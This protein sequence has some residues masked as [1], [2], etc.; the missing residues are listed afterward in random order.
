[1]QLAGDSFPL[2]PTGVENCEELIHKTL[3]YIYTE[4]VDAVN[5]VPLESKDN[6]NYDRMVSATDRCRLL[7]VKLTALLKWTKNIE[8]IKRCQDLVLY[9]NTNIS[10]LSKIAETFNRLVFQLLTSLQ[11]IF[12]FNSALSVLDQGVYPF[13]PPVCDS[14][15]PFLSRLQMKDGKQLIRRI[16]KTRILAETVPSFVSSIRVEDE[17]IVCEEP[18]LF[19][20][21]I[22]TTVWTGN[23]FDL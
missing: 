3:A 8:V 19:S 10:T 2:L 9:D 5:S 22:T 11:P 7:L 17:G 14:K 21:S 12:P 1:M 18:H 4:L 16:L 15:T 6:Q 13:I 23:S 20:F